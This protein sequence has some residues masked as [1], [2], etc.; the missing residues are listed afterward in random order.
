MAMQIVEKG[1]ATFEAKSTE[2]HA[3]DYDHSGL[4][5]FGSRE[6]QGYAKIKF[7]LRRMIED[8][9]AERRRILGKPWPIITSDGGHQYLTNLLQTKKRGGRTRTGRSLYQEITLGAALHH[10]ATWFPH[11]PYRRS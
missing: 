5:K 11:R 2:N 7:A 1:S 3:L 8:I 4:N 9:N 6:D 10:S